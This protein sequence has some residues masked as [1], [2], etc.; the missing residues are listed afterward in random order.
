MTK[1]N[2]SLA[3]EKTRINTIR[4]EREDIIMNASEIKQIIKDYYE[5]LYGNQ[6]DN[7]E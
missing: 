3:R 5:H 4:N 2:K 1:I 7:L 6:L